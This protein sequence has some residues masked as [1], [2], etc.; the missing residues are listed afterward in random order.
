MTEKEIIYALEC[1]VSDDDCN[2]CPCYKIYKFGCTNSQFT[3]DTLDLIKR[4]RRAIKKW[5]QG[6]VQLRDMLD[7]RQADNERLKKLLEE[8]EAKYKEIAKR[9]Y[10]VGVREFAERLC[11]GRISNDP[12]VIAVKAELKEMVCDME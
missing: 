7:N 6:N 12:V 1:C 3:R 5:Q 2:K 8:S 10:K 4:Q 11:K 9:F